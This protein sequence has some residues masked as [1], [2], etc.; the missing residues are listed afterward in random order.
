MNMMPRPP[1][2]PAKS[3]APSS[4]D[5][6]GEDRVTIRPRSAGVVTRPIAGP[7]PELRRPTAAPA[8]PSTPESKADDLMQVIRQLS[9]LL[10]KENSALKRHKVDEVRAMTE[11]KETLSRTYQQQLN[12]F[13][14]DPEIAKKMDRPKRE[15]LIQVSAKLS[16]LMAENASLLK[17]N[18]TVIEKF[19]K[20]VVD[21]V[22]ERQQA[23][24][25]AYS[26]QGG[27]AAYGF[28]KRH[29]A[30]SYNATS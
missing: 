19:L 1:L 21:A 14:R 9:D 15:A 2:P 10:A 7:T 26:K 6:R 3:A 23:R 17:V 20:T 8:R 16:Q 12:G 13:H 4:G 18:M 22:K 25:A 29:L 11:R 28:S 5:V 27:M 24:S 30:V